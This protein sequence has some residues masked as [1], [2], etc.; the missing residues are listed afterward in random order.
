MQSENGR[1][2]IGIDI[3]GT[4]TKIAGL[5]ETGALQCL[6][7]RATDP[8]ASLYGAFGKFL[9]QA[10]LTLDRVCHVM[11]TGVGS[12]ALQTP[13]Y[14]I[15]TSLVDEFYCTGRG[16]LYLSGLEEGIIV[17]MGTGTA[18]VEATKDYISHI[19]GTGVGG[20][21]LV[22]LS[23]AVLG[24]RDVQNLAKLAEQG[25]LKK[26]DLSIGDITT[27]AVSNLPFDA[28][29]SNFGKLSELATP[30]DIALGLFNLVYQTIGM[31]AV[32]ASRGHENK[33]IVLTG[34][35]SD[36]AECRPIFNA[37]S[38]MY[39]VRFHVPKQAQFA[40]A[41]GAALSY[42]KEPATRLK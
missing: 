10:G 8:L 34:N 7:V 6:Q 16:G 32:F 29:A 20:G 14:G 30:E 22:G 37:L 3:G 24:V 35:L 38:E 21:T 17:S 13:I 4:I 40:T 12:S 1:F 9:S 31:L 42:G 25:D 2:I 5:D 19:G 27:N 33:E 23:T 11:V 26:V 18:Y 15:P 41:V 28:T 39:Q 36:M